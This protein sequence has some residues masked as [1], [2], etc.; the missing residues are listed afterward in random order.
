MFPVFALNYYIFSVIGTSEGKDLDVADIMHKKKN[1][2]KQTQT[3]K[4]KEKNPPQLNQL[5][6][7]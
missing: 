1:K 6:T 5:E 2:T 3:P 7:Y 4:Q